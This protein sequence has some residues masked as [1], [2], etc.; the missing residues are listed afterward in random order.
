MKL[1]TQGI[2]L[3]VVGAGMFA[4]PAQL[5]QAAP[6][7]AKADPGIQ[8]IKNEA[9]GD[10]A[11]RANKATGKIGF[12][13]VNGAD[14]DL[15]PGRAATNGS[16]AAAKAGAYLAEHSAAFG[17][18]NGE[19]GAALAP[20]LVVAVLGCGQR[21]ARPD[22]RREERPRLDRVLRPEVQGP[23]GLRFEDQ[24]QRRQGR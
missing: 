23:R 10:V 2:A 14:A 1:L 6:Q 20:P 5:A 9:K 3:A 18:A 22:R 8:A 13:A 4:V 19:L 11:L 21:R 24:G 17:A 15:M 12:A 7:A 16:E